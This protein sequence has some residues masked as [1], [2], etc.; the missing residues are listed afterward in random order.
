[1]SG[2]FDERFKLRLQSWIDLETLIEVALRFR[3]EI[4][5]EVTGEAAAAPGA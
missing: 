2:L 4:A 3:F 1:M 5:S